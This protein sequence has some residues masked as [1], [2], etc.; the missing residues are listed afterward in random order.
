MATLIKKSQL[1]IEGLCIEL[2]QKKIKSVSIR[3]CPPRGE[4][5]VSAPLH[6]SREKILSTLRP[7]VNWMLNHQEKYQRIYKSSL[8]IKVQGPSLHYLGI[9]YPYALSAHP[10]LR[11][12]VRVGDR[13]QVFVKDTTLAI[14]IER[15]IKHWYLEK[16]N[17]HLKFFVEK[18]AL[19]LNVKVASWRIKQM[20]SKWGCCH[21]SER[22]L[23]FNLEL[24]KH[25]VACIE[26]VVVHE[27]VHLIEASHNLRFKRFMTAAVPNWKFLKKE[28]EQS[29]LSSR[30]EKT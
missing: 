19:I 15:E 1:E 28:L 4:I 20:R 18:W 7:K 2:I 16:L 5:L 13:Y 14:S 29:H 30:I 9:S 26:Y 10:K 3:V 22:H 8:E 6:Y 25:P 12:P 27:L 17:E 11:G 21:V 24:I 23:V